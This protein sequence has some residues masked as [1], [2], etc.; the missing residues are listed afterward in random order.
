MP[1]EIA[2]IGSSLDD[3]RDFP[4]AARREAGHQPHLLQLGLKPDDWRPMPSVGAG[5]LELRIHDDVE[6]RVF[7]VVKFAEAIYVL[8]A[9]EKKTRQTSQH[10][11]DLGRQRLKGLHQWRREEGL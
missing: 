2:W 6:H 8:H 10:D 4:D 9:F 7:Y 3:L 11:L 5:V 1:K